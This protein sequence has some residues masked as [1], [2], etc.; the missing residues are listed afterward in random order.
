MKKETIIA[1]SIIG[2]II[3]GFGLYS[4]FSNDN[5]DKLCVYEIPNHIKIECPMENETQ[6]INYF[7]PSIF[8]YK[9][10]LMNGCKDI[11][12]LDDYGYKYEIAKCEDSIPFEV[13]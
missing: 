11:E 3:L 6:V 13:K 12:R 4:Y 1:I 7:Q 10:A 8:E 2:V 5:S 9:N